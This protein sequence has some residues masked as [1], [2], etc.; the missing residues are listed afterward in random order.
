MV[1]LVEAL[2]DKP[3]VAVS[4][5]DGVT[6]IFGRLNPSGHRNGGKG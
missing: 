1:Q 3:E 2:S 5:P 6:E 4:I